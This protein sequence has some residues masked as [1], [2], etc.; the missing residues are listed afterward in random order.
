MPAHR[1]RKP[2][3]QYQPARAQNAGAATTCPRTEH[4]NPST[5]TNLPAH[6][7]QDRSQPARALFTGARV[8]EGADGGRGNTKSERAVSIETARTFA[9][10]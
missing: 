9:A 6:R 2:Q 3:Y 1:T 7:T 8:E 10:N 5:H 4:G